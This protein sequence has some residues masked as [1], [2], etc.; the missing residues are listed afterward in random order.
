MKVTIFT[1]MTNPKERMDP[2]KEALNCYE[3]FADDIVTVGKNWPYEFEWKEIGK[4]FQEGFDAAGGD[5]A[6][7]M[8][9]DMF[10][11]ENIKDK[12]LKV[13]KKHKNEPAIAIPKFKFFSPKKYEFKNFEILIINKKKFPNIKFDGGGDL[14]LP[15]LNG[16]L[17]DYKNI[18][19]ENIPIWN[20]DTTFRTKEVIAEDRAR[21][22]R[23]WFREFDDWGDR[24]GPDPEKA[25]KAWFDMVEERLA[26]H[27]NKLEIDAHP[28]F[29]SETLYSLN[30]NQFGYN[31]FGLEKKV[32]PSMK[33]YFDYLKLK[34]KFP[35]IKIR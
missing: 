7:N 13:L 34:L 12:L 31:C 23:A 30:E 20:Y 2:W 26:R 3:F 4:N 8:P 21:F 16:V 5:W 24:G 11:H 27:I 10:F 17:L 19:I 14:C 22:A 35:N 15:T 29:I 33:T 18:P 25:F 1:H 9:L 32:N 6:I 28:K